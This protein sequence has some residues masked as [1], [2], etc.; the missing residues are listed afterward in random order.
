MPSR[1]MIGLF[2]IHITPPEREVVPPTCPV[3]STISTDFPASRSTSP[4]HIEPPPLPTTTKSWLS[5]NCV[6]PASGRIRDE[7]SC[8]SEEHTSDLQS[9]MRISYAVL[10]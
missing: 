7:Q 6:M 5:S 1:F 8:R 9:L 3:F 10:W 4:A 2:G